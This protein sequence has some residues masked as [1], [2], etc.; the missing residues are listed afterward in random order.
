MR[1]LTP[2]Q[3][4]GRSCVHCGKSFTAPVTVLYCSARCKKR[5]REKRRLERRRLEG[6]GK[7]GRLQFI[8]RAHEDREAAQDALRA[9]VDAI[10]GS[11]EESFTRGNRRREEAREAR[12]A[13]AVESVV[14]H[15]ERF[16][17]A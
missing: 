13:A 8:I 2:Q 15:F 1:Q 4:T 17:N 14:T 5:Y 7:A 3:K 11:I 16:G 12:V 6:K 10:A 9:R